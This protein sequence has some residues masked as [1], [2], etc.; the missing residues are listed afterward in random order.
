MKEMTNELLKEI[1]KF[2]E[3]NFNKGCNDE[4][5]VISVVNEETCTAVTSPWYDSSARFPLTD[6]EAVEE[7][8]LTT[9]IQFCDKAREHM[10]LHIVSA[11]TELTGGG[12]VCVFGKL[13]NG[14]Y[15]IF[16]S[17]EREI[18][19][20]CDDTAK[21]I[22]DEHVMENA[23]EWASQHIIETIADV[24]EYIRLLREAC[25]LNKK[26]NIELFL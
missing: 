10:E 17:L 2:A 22:Y 15:Y 4:E 19:I 6:K 1:K 26:I 5:D 21:L 8:G 16:Q 7:W 23:Y 14:N 12:V 3:E 24:S 11:E 18:E 20:Y 13:N 9:V 25:K